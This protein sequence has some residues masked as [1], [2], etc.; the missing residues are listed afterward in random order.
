MTKV[1]VELLARSEV[2]V[3]IA[4]VKMLK[5]Q[6]DAGTYFVDSRAVAHKVQVSHMLL[7]I[8]EYEKDDISL[9]TQEDESQQ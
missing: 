3:R 8:T 1:K 7:S 2:A 6:V 9:P 5:A 4:R